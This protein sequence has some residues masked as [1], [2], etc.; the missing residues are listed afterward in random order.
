MTREPSDQPVPH[1]VRA[2]GRIEPSRNILAEDSLL[3]TVPGKSLQA[4]A[5][6]TERALLRLCAG[7]LSVAEAAAYLG[8]PVSVVKVVASDLIDTGHLQVR[9]RTDGDPDLDLLEE[10]LHGLR[11]L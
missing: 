9:P 3:L 6:R 2:R 10:V 5:T 1:Y 4:T 8:L 7:Q 11:A